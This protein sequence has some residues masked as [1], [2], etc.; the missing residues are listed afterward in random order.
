FYEYPN[1]KMSSPCL[2]LANQSFGILGEQFDSTSNTNW[3]Y[4]VKEDR[5]RKNR[6]Y[7][8]GWIADQRQ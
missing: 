7:N 1:K 6:I 2:E 8:L 4:I 3:L 5:Y